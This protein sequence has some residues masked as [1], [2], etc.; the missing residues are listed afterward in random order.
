MDHDLDAIA[1]RDI[2]ERRSG[3]A[4][5]GA[6]EEDLEKMMQELLL[7]RSFGSE[8]LRKYRERLEARGEPAQEQEAVGQADSPSRGKLG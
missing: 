7:Q 4:P 5:P 1:S 8:R 6:T 2:P 3:L